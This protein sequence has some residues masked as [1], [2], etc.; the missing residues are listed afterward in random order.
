MCESKNSLFPCLR[1]L[2][3]KVKPNLINLKGT[4]NNRKLQLKGQK[5][6]KYCKFWCFSICLRISKYDFNIVSHQKILI[7][8]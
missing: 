8:G 2:Y 4:H 6:F 5:K 1:L 3:P 7:I